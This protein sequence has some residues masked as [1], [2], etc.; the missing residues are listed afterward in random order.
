[1][2]RPK[3]GDMKFRTEEHGFSLSAVF[4][5]NSPEITYDMND[6]GMLWQVAIIWS[7]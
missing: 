6:D 7:L 5:C 2:W 4:D 1:M 3:S